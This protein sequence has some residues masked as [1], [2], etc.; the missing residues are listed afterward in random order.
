MPNAARPMTSAVTDAS[1]TMPNDSD[2]KSPR[3]SSSAKNTAAIGALNVAEMP[4][5]APH[6]T[7]RRIRAGGTRSRCPSVEPSAEPIW[8]IGPSR[9]TDPPVPIQIAEAID[10]T[11]ATLGEMRPP[12]AA[13]GVH[14]LRYAV[15]TRFLCEAIDQRAVEETTDG[16]N[17]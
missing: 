6:A 7:S 8:T 17:E 12:R 5:A 1:T 16:G 11:I 4:P 10:F 3:M 9:P 13:D 15:A 14:H 2:A